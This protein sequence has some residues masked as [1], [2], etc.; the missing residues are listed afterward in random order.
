M[1]FEFDP[2]FNKILY[3]LG[4]HMIH[5]DRHDLGYFSYKSR[6]SHRYNGKLAPIHESVLHHWQL[7]S[8]LVLMSQ[9]IHLAQMGASA[10]DEENLNTQEAEIN[11]NEPR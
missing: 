4:T 9:L 8:I 3:D 2:D 1:G 10:M 5:D 6:N 11:N 7:G